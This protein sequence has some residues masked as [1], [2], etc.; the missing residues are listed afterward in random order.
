MTLKRES[1]FIRRDIMLN[2]NRN[3]PIRGPFRFPDVA[4]TSGRIEA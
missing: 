2:A 4:P 1:I 3:G